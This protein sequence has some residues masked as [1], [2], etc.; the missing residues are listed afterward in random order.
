MRLGERGCE[1]NNRLLQI[2]VAFVLGVALA[3]LVPKLVIGGLK[4]VLFPDHRSEVSRVTSPDGIV[5]AVMVLSNCGAPC[6]ANYSIVV[7]PRGG[8][9]PAD[10]DQYVFSADDMVNPKL[11]WNQP[12]LLQIAFTKALINNF[13]NLSHPFGVPGK[14]ESWNYAVEIRLAPSS[15]D[16][17]YLPEDK[18]ARR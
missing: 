18:R 12:H 11:S 7:V 17:S 15:P 1:L 6:P 9:A 14:V 13:R 5:D 3:I 8:K 2:T 10:L 16:F 4:K